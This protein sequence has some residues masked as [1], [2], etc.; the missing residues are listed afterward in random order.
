MPLIK[1]YTSRPITK[2]D[3]DMFSQFLLSI[4]QTDLVILPAKRQIMKNK[5]VYNNADETGCVNRSGKIVYKYKPP[6]I[7]ARAADIILIKLYLFSIP[8]FKSVLPG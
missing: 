5:M 2:I 1:E 7:P 6:I 4:F 3:S 8:G